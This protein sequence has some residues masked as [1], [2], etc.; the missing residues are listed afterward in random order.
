M[1]N[2]FWILKKQSGGRSS[3]PYPVPLEGLIY[4]AT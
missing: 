4:S 3:S 1:Q 2:I